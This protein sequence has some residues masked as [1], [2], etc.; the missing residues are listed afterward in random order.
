MTFRAYAESSPAGEQ[1]RTVRAFP[2]ALLAANGMHALNPDALVH[3]L[4]QR[5]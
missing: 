5:F 4:R 1:N 2:G 3:F